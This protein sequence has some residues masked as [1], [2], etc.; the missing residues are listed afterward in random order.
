MSTSELTWPLL[1]NTVVSGED[2]SHEQARWAMDEIMSGNRSGVEIAG[3]LMALQTKGESVAEVAG[4]ADMMVEHAVPLDVP[5]DA[6]DIVGTGGDQAFTVN[7]STMSSIVIAATGRTVI[8]HGNRA[9]SSKSGSADCIEALGV[10]LDLP[11]ETV[12]AMAD[13]VGITFAFANVFHPAM[14]FAA[15]ARKGLRVPTVFNYLG[16]ITNPGKPNASAVGVANARMAPIIAGVFA[17]RGTSALVFRGQDGLDELTV[18]APSDVWEVRQGQVDQFVLD[19]FALFGIPR[20]TIADLRGGSAVENAA[21]AREI[22]AGRTG[23][24]RE[25]VLLNAA[26]GIAVADGIG[27]APSPDDFFD[28]LTAARDLAARTLDDGGATNKIA[29]WVAATAG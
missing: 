4:L 22:F 18:T 20:S 21:I 23:P 28:R 14:R 24:I 29:E 19:P 26:A 11:V 12:A 5:T 3:L 25:A 16:P 2:L 7:I 13:R 27:Q 10:R 6:I 1:L 17:E 9:S 8:K 15:E